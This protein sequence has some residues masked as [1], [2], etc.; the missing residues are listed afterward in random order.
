MEKSVKLY[1]A[2]KLSTVSAG[3]LTPCRR[4]SFNS[5]SG[6]IDPSI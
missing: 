5:V 1:Q 4:A 2:R 3:S 6:R